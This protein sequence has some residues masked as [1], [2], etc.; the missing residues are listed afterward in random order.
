MGE[1]IDSTITTEDSLNHKMENGDGIMSSEDSP[2]SNVKYYTLEEIQAHN[3]SKDT[4]L[5]IHDKVYD[6]TSFMEEVRALSQMMV[7]RCVGKAG[8]YK[9]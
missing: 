5:I 8:L 3:L 1:E 6:I 7:A 2:E 9:S 4:W